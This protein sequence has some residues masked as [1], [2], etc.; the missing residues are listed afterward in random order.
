M[1]TFDLDAYGVSEMNHEEMST[2]EAGNIFVAAW[3]W[4]KTHVL[5]HPNDPT[6]HVDV[7]I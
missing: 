3:T 4:V 6:F 5:S 1:K 7:A 2:T